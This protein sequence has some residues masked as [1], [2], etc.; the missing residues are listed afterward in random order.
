MLL[1][2][3][4]TVILILIDIGIGATDS[5]DFWLNLLAEGH[6]IIGDILF[7]GIAISIYDAIIRRRNAVNRLEEDLD[8]YRE[9]ASEE[10]THRIIGTLRSLN[11][12][13][14]TIFN[15]NECYLLGINISGVTFGRSNFNHAN[16][17]KSTLIGEYDFKETKIASLGL[18]SSSFEDCTL[19]KTTFRNLNL[20]CT[21]F[22][23]AGFK[24]KVWFI[25]CNLRMAS[26]PDKFDNPG[27]IKFEK[28][29]FYSFQT[30]ELLKAGI[31]KDQL[32]DNR[33][34]RNPPQYK[35]LK[36]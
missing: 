10:A 14:V 23:S 24:N 18:S 27:I 3:P 31:D 9:W 6:G 26:F 4:I 17:T 2:I 21:N 29:I 16:L 5:N 13:G 35:L 12:Y 19:E 15:L 25:G 33:F 36:R 20:S 34:N 1:F 22:K 7:F 28:C 8:I 32:K 30:E 11:N